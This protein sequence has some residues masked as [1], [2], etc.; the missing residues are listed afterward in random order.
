MN[1]LQRDSMH[2]YH[3]NSSQT[4][5]QYGK[6]DKKSQPY[7]RSYWKPMVAALSFKGVIF[8]SFNQISIDRFM[9]KNIWEHEFKYIYNEIVQG[10]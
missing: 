7:L 1:S 2:E 6:M 3:V 8:G 4:K 5:S 9:L 10:G